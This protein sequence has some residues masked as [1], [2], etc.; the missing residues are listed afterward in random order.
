MSALSFPMKISLIVKNKKW[1]KFILKCDWCQ[2][3]FIYKYSKYV[4]LESVKLKNWT[5]PRFNGCKGEQF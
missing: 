4:A 3:N 2:D 1:V 5:D